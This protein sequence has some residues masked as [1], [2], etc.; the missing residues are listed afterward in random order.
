MISKWPHTSQK[1]HVNVVTLGEP[2]F[3]RC[4]QTVPQRLISA[5]GLSWTVDN[6]GTVS[7]G[8]LLLLECKESKVPALFNMVFGSSRLAERP[9]TWRFIMADSSCISGSS[10]LAFPVTP[11]KGMSNWKPEG[12][13]QWLF[14]FFFPESEAIGKLYNIRWKAMKKV[15]KFGRNSSDGTKRWNAKHAT[16]RGPEGGLI[17]GFHLLY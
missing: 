16:W 11:S 2:L 4:N 13:G 1:G 14:L 3:K 8:N 10:C 5:F 6:Y 12:K 9:C 7:G 17:I 15:E